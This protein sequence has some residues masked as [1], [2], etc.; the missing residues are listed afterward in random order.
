MSS[1]RKNFFFNQQQLAP[2]LTG[3]KVRPS[4][5]DTR[6]YIYQSTNAVL[7]DRVDLREYASPVEDQY[8]LGSCTGNALTSAYEMLT[9]IQ[10]PEKFVELSRLFVYY[11][12]RLIEGTAD[13]DSGAYLRDGIKAI[14]RH[15]LCKEDLWPYVT[16]EFATPPPK[17]CYDDAR[18]RSIKNYRKLSGVT[19]I[20]DA[21]N[22]KRPVA[23]G[24]AVY[25]GFMDLNRFNSVLD[26][27][28][29]GE[30]SIGGHAM[31]MVG[32]DLLKKQFLALNSFG[33]DWG[34]QG[35]CWITFNYVRQEIYDVWTFDLADAIEPQEKFAF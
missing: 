30:P 35:Y 9:R 17:I 34:V 7:E 21:L 29:V 22:N 26:V 1:F 18:T 12:I 8:D 28:P 25:D 23:F 4:Q 19:D 20:L 13:I 10:A 15:G 6:D 14:R 33:L 3:F 5:T 32:Y 11:N 2:K 31:L 24:M 16:E 27:P